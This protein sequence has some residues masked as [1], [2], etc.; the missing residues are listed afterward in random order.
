MEET[1]K[2]AQNGDK[3]ALNKVMK[4]IEQSLYK[5]AI[6]KLKNK[7][8]AQDVV[9]DT[10]ILIYKNLK[11]LKNPTHFKTWATRILINECNKYYRTKSKRSEQTENIDNII[12]FEMQI[13]EVTQKIDTIKVLESLE[14]KERNIMILHINGYRNNEIAEILK[15]KENTVKTKIRRCKEKIKQ[16]YVVDKKDRNV[17]PVN[18]SLH[19]IISAI[20]VILLTTGIVYASVKIVKFIQ[21]EKEN[22]E[23]IKWAKCGIEMNADNITIVEYMNK[24]DSNTYFLS[25]K[26]EQK[27]NEMKDILEI[28]F[29][30]TIN[31][32][33]FEKY[34]YDVLILA[35]LNEE[36]LSV[37]SVLPYKNKLTIVLTKK[38]AGEKKKAFCVFV[39]KLYNNENIEIV[40]EEEKT[41][42]EPPKDAVHFKFSE[43][44][45]EKIEKFDELKLKY[46]NEKEV[47]Y[48][49]FLDPN[50]YYDLIAEL[51]IVTENNLSKDLSGKEV[52]LIF[53]KTNNKL[54]FRKLSKN[55]GILQIN[56]IETEEEYGVGITGVLM[57][58]DEGIFDEYKAVLTK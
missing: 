30:E 46:D 9:Q 40:Y 12:D 47:Y 33:T 48:T 23:P 34:E 57:I 29:E 31:N 2:K 42:I 3:D 44:Y 10:M 17:I 13:N 50:S 4:E 35:L 32:D 16:N 26:D 41:E 27:L 1:I 58:F 38:S 8:D 7:E 22:P 21:E 24:Y 19:T 54:D 55:D 43:F 5:F 56:L 39:P 25:I 45:V 18:K 11:Q 49:E 52:V 53:K 15:M 36:T 28:D 51:G 6:L 37:Q 20:L 14:T